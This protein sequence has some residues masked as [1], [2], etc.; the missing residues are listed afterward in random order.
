MS[1]KKE[2]KKGERKKV[3]VTLNVRYIVK[4]GKSIEEKKKKIEKSAHKSI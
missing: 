4:N 1:I 2:E 3:D